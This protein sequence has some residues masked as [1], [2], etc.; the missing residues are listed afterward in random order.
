MNG[1]RFIEFVLWVLSLVLAIV[2]FYNGASKI[3]E[4]PYQVA[5]FEALGLPG[6]LLIA[7][8]VMECVAGLMLTIPRLSLVGG[9]LLGVMMLASAGLHF[10]HDNIT[11]SFRAVVLI[12]MLAGICYLRFKRG[13]ARK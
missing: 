9:I 2:F 8:G 13:S 4:Y 6:N 3:M 7:V 11:S 12:V 10:V 5:Q 1:D